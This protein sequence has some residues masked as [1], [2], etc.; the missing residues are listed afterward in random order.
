MNCIKIWVIFFSVDC[1]LVFYPLFF[2]SYVLLPCW[3]CCLKMVLHWHAT[4]VRALREYNR[5]GN[6]EFGDA[7]HGNWQ[8]N[9]GKKTMVYCEFKDL[10]NVEYNRNQVLR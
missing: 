4:M 7:C 10:V 5:D 1:V 6:G 3:H 8:L 2:K 9:D